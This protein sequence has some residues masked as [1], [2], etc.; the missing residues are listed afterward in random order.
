MSAVL[1]IDNLSENLQFQAGNDVLR[2]IYFF[3]YSLQ[4][5]IFMKNGIMSMTSLDNSALYLLK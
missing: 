4:F 2:H 3:T 1:P 5:F